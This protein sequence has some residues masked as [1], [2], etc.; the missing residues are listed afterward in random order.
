MYPLLYWNRGH[1]CAVALAAVFL[2][3]DEISDELLLGVHRA[4]IAF[5]KAVRGAVGASQLA[6]L[7]DVHAVRK[8]GISGLAQ[9]RMMSSAGVVMGYPPE[10]VDRRLVDRPPR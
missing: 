9:M 7:T 1:L 10:Y 2:S 5:L 6:Q 8:A 4:P 3:R